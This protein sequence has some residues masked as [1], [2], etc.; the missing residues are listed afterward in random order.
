MQCM[1]NFALSWYYGSI[2]Q[3][4]IRFSLMHYLP[5]DK[6]GELSGFEHDALSDSDSLYMTSMCLDFQPMFAQPDCLT[7]Q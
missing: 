7:G 6:V 3:F 1:E 4:F 2:G 5:A